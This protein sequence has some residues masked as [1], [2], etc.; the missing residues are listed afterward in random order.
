ME[1]LLRGTDWIFKLHC[2]ILITS[3]STTYLSV[4]SSAG[5]SRDRRRNRGQ[6][7]RDTV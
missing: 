7:K 3:Y 2:V 5:V 1:C 6:N 4:S